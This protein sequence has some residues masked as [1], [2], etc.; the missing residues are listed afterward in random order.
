MT[1]EY[2][3]SSY[4]RHELNHDQTALGRLPFS[5]FEDVS[6][7]VVLTSINFLNSEKVTN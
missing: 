1:E 2:E 4:D 3:F 7:Q 5:I 6:I